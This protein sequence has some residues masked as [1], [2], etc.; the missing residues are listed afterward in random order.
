MTK[1]YLKQLKG[2]AYLSSTLPSFIIHHSLKRIKKAL[3][4]S[5]NQGFASLSIF[6]TLLYT[7]IKHTVSTPD[8]HQAT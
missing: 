6:K 8:F 3:I 5:L 4:Y 1:P 7:L 2:I